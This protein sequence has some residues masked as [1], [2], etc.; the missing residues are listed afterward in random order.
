MIAA[1][2]QA[3]MGSTRLPGKVIKEVKGRPLLS[4]L[5]ERLR[6]CRGIEKIIIATSINK[7]DDVIALLAEREGIPVYRGSQDDVLDRYYQT[8]IKY[9]VDNIVRITADCPLIDPG[10]TEEV[11]NYYLNNPGFDLVL[12]GPTYPEGFDTSIFPFKTL[13]TAWNEANLKSDREH[14]TTFIWKNDKRF[15]IKTLSLE[16]DYS[17]LRLTVDEPVDFEVAK[18]VIEEMYDEKG[19]VFFFKD[20]LCLYKKKPYIFEQ[21]KNVIR[22]EGYLLSLKEDCIINAGNRKKG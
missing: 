20:I 1:I 16:E 5:I 3:R 6:S 21:N 2:V 7:E 19:S 4:Y 14:V 17:F 13:K 12:T 11:I 8:A 18:N 9:Q 22:N 15:K 10:V